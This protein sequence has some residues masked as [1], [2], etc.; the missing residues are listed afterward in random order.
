M[1]VTTPPFVILATD[2]LLLIHVPPIFGV[3]LVVFPTQI[4]L[5]PV[6]LTIGFGLTFMFISG[7]AT[8]P[9]SL[10]TVTW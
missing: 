3:K 5:G 9:K 6:I 8:Q 4:S 1:P 7:T 10:V 2:G